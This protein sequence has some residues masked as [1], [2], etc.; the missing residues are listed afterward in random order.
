[1]WISGPAPANPNNYGA[2]SP[3][4]EEKRSYDRGYHMG[5][6]DFQS[7]RP[8]HLCPPQGQY[9]QQWEEA[10]I[11]GYYDGYDAARPDTNVMRAEE[12]DSYDDAYRLGQKDY[13]GRIEKPSL[14]ALRGSLRSPVRALFPK[15]LCR[16][17]L[18]GSLA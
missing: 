17:L 2:D 15:G 10:F 8:P 13:R 3:V 6:D 4:T 18:L 12:K 11:E 9:N 5:A 16:R 7:A 14:Y 1:V